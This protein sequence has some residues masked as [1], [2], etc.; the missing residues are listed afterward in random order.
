MTLVQEE[1]RLLKVDRSIGRSA[2]VTQ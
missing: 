2:G 1:A